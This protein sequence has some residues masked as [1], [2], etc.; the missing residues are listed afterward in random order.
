[1]IKAFNQQAVKMLGRALGVSPQFNT[2]RILNTVV[3]CAAKGN[4]HT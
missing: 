4:K 1:M 3:R 2:Y